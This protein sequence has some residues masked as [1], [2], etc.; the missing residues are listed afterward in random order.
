MFVQTIATAST[1]AL[2]DRS[3]HLGDVAFRHL[4]ERK[5]VLKAAMALAGTG[6]ARL[7]ASCLRFS[8]WT[9]SMYGVTNPI[10]E[11]PVRSK[12]SR[13]ASTDVQAGMPVAA[14]MRSHS[15]SSRSK[16]SQLADVPFQAMTST[17]ACASNS[18]ARKISLSSNWR[19]RG[20]RQRDFRHL[21][22]R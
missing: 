21:E 12:I 6:N 7:P 14:V 2:R 11:T 18:A 22:A 8:A 10:R 19:D 13:K 16:P 1:P 3:N 4:R 5:I 15:R 20:I 9:A 17:L